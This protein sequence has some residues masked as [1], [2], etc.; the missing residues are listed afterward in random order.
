MPYFIIIPFIVWGTIQC[1][2]VGIDIYQKGVFKR[3]YLWWSGWFPSVHSGMSASI[4]TLTYI[5]QWADSLLFAITIIFS[6]LLWYDAVNVRYEAWKH[7][8]QIN[9]LQQTMEKVVK[10]SELK[11]RIGHTP[12]EVASGII[13]GIIVTVMLYYIFPTW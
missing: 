11:E 4:I 7:A 3:S 2:K 9:Y 13:V 6:F 5:T 1:I 10:K 12:Q 8:H